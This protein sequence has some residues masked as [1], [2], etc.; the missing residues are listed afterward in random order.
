MASLVTSKT[1]VR[2]KTVHYV[3]S[4]T[5]DSAT[6][7]A[8]LAGTIK[9]PA[10]SLVTAIATSGNTRTTKLAG[11]VDTVW[12]AAETF[13]LT[14]SSVSAALKLKPEIAALTGSSTAANIV[15]A[16]QA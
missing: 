5:A 7:S 3:V 15:S 2:Q 1:A 14:S 13:T 16:L 4:Q 8:L 10:N 6:Y 9:M 12:S 11:E